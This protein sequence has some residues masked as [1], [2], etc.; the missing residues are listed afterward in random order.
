MTGRIETADVI[1][2]SPGR[3]FVT[4]KLVTSDGVVGW[5]DATVNGRELA[6]AAYLSEHVV[7]LL[8]GR[9]ADRI[10]DTWQYLYR[11]AYW[12]RGPITMAA[13]GAVDMALWD[14]K[15]KVA[16]LPVYQLLGG[17][18]RDKVLA[19]THA[20]G[21]DTPALLDAVREKLDRGFRAVRVQSGIP[22]LDTVYGVGGGTG[23]EPAGRGARPAE[24]LWDT[25]RYLRH[26]PGVLAEVRAMTGPEVK[27]LHD[28]HHRLTPTE[29][30]GLGKALEGLDL[31]WLEDVTPAE[32]QELLRQVRRHT[33]VPLAIGEVFN[34]VWDCRELITERLIDYIRTCV[35]HA[36]GI[37]HVRKIFQLAELYQVAA[38]PHGPSDVSPVNLAASLHVGL[39][40]Y[41]FAV[42][43][44]MGYPALTEEAFPHAYSCSDGYLHPG[45]APGLGVEL[46]EEFAARH[47]YQRAY[48]PVARLADGTVK[49][50]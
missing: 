23:Y 40:T 27:L 16:G 33:T 31:F 18:V 12:R 32:N 25:G 41:N 44:Y 42:Q 14:I 26:I 48:L 9:D 39:A 13:I 19:Y 47:P 10:E 6:V 4:L 35:V 50:W 49:D 8:I 24:E 2:A 43:E 38:A 28:V 36:G 1:V 20:T 30:A 45:D 5:G 37:S 46:D 15:G 22:G 17:A 3:N 7:P 21:A 11:G 34:T 29:A